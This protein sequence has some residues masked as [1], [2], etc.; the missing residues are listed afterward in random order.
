MSEN[1]ITAARLALFVLAAIVSAALSGGV[2]YAI[3]HWLL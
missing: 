3:I 1:V 2:T